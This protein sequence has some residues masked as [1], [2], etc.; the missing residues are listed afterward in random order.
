MRG[1]AL[2]EMGL[3]RTQ[4]EPFVV[5]SLSSQ[6]SRKWVSA[7]PGAHITYLGEKLNF[8]WSKSS[9]TLTQ[10]CELLPW[11]KSAVCVSKD[12]KRM[13][14]RSCVFRRTAS[15]CLDEYRKLTPNRCGDLRDIAAAPGKPRPGNNIS[16]SQ[17]LKSNGSTDS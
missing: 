8:L 17:F 14:K 13:V 1:L 6:E 10:N 4:E 3:C 9:I 12:A 2:L 5:P 16:E 15:D 11:F 7:P